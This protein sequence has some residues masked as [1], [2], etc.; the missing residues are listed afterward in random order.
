MTRMDPARFERLQD[1]FERLR[2]LPAAEQ[3]SR[4]EQETRGDAELRA[5]LDLLLARHREL[6]GPHRSSDPLLDRGGPYRL[7]T[8]VDGAGA[9]FEPESFGRYRTTALLGRG[10]MGTVH[11]ARDTQLDRDVALKRIRPEL[12]LSR[13]MRRRFD[14]ETRAASRLDHPHI[15]KVF[16]AGEHDGQPFLV[17]QYLRGESLAAKI[18]AATPLDVESC[19]SWTE[20]IARALHHAHEHGL[21]H[22]DVKPSNILVDHDGEPFLLDFGL[23]RTQEP[24]EA[25]TATGEAPGTYRY[26]SPEQVQNVEVDAR[27]DVFSL[28][29]VLAELLL[30]RHPFASGSGTDIEIVHRIQHGEPQLGARQQR[31]L[32]TDLTA[33]LQKALARDRNARYA[34]ALALAEDLARVRRHQPLVAGRTGRVRA[35]Q[36][37]AQR[38]PVATLCA[39][40]LVGAI[41]LSV[42]LVDQL[43]AR[44]RLEHRAARLDEVVASLREVVDMPT[45]PVTALKVAVTAA[46]AGPSPDAVLWRCLAAAGRSHTIAKYPALGTPGY[47]RTLH[48][49][50]IW[51]Q[52]SADPRGAMLARVST[53]GLLLI[54]R[55]EDDEPV[56]VLRANT[57]SVSTR[58]GN[59]LAFDPAGEHLFIGGIDGMVSVLRTSD[60]SLATAVPLVADPADPLR[61]ESIESL[62]L[63]LDG[64]WLAAGGAEGHLLLFDRETG[65]TRSTCLDVHQANAALAFDS[66]AKH[67]LVAG[68][69]A[70]RIT[71][72]FGVLSI[73]ELDPPGELRSSRLRVFEDAAMHS[74]CW[75]PEGRWVAVGTA[76]GQL[77][78]VDTLHGESRSL[79]ACPTGVPPY[80]RWCGF[81]LAG[82][83]LVA[84]AAPGLLVLDWSD[85]AVGNR[86]VIAHPHARAAMSASFR[87]DGRL[88]AVLFGD[89]SLGFVATS[90]WQLRQL[91]VATGLATAGPAAHWAG[92]ERVV[93]TANDRFDVWQAPPGNL[94]SALCEHSGAVRSVDAHPDAEV[95]LAAGDDGC[96]SIQDHGT[97][98][99]RRIACD[100]EPQRHVRFSPDGRHFVAVGERSVRVFRTDGQ[101]PILQRS[102]S[103]ALFAGNDRLFVAKDRTG[104]VFDLNGTGLDGVDPPALAVMDGRIM[105]AAFDDEH[106]CIVM[107]GADRNAWRA[108]LDRNSPDAGIR[109][110]VRNEHGPG[111]LFGSV[112]GLAVP[113]GSGRILVSC[114]NYYFAVFDPGWS[115]T[116]TSYSYA[117]RFGGPIAIDPQ[118]RCAAIADYSFGRLSWLDLRTLDADHM[119]A[120]DVHTGRITAIRFSRSGRLCLTASL[121]GTVC[122]WDPETRTLKGRMRLEGTTVEDACFTADERWFVT[123]DGRGAVQRWPVEP[124]PVATE[125]LEHFAGHSR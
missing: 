19:L 37:W 105:A 102:G 65:A 88:L 17:M 72:S 90:D 20:K 41:A 51:M 61:R 44:T 49:D 87:A 114:I 92:N 25:L 28:A 86:T 110:D 93:T 124:L 60:W 3:R 35:L 116:P 36:S 45:E 2:E 40:L 113:P 119:V 23:A 38:H 101:A 125:Y 82:R 104:T 33:V 7:L 64:R 58:W 76:D 77:L 43:A 75:H 39:G 52:A 66:S 46:E 84:G 112:A 83:H 5:E 85:G 95:V 21:V 13:A 78:A 99:R 67:L 24:G 16:D 31:R 80:I 91:F 57:F 73:V 109:I 68:R 47:D 54:T 103:L 62:C 118:R 71:P 29:V 70:G 15:C 34:S 107:G 42:V 11:L 97:G 121:D 79:A 1:L 100:G 117:D 12:L 63:S 120:T 115:L 111:S 6:A 108:C 50:E 32:G 10:G 53:H 48:P 123:G 94:V 9:A 27:T 122:L 81:D 55:V 106:G 30:L 98:A 4:S 8:T 26:M 14:N 59:V 96:I 22:R 69:P 89:G 74:F 18:A 56:R